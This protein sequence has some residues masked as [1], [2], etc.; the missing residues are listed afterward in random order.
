MTAIRNIRN[1]TRVTM[2]T[3][4]IPAIAFDTHGF[5]S[6]T[7]KLIQRVRNPKNSMNIPTI[8]RRRFRDV[9]D[10]RNDW[11]PSTILSAPTSTSRIVVFLM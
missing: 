3:R 7:A 4:P 5:C 2:K 1:I 6:H 9:V 8:A 11:Y 10:Q